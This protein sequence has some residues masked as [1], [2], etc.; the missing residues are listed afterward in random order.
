MPTFTVLFVTLLVALG[1]W[2]G[3]AGAAP[4]EPAGPRP[5]VLTKQKPF[6]AV[7]AGPKQV[8]PGDT[9]RVR[10]TVYLLDD[11]HYL[12]KDAC[13]VEVTDPGPF[14]FGPLRYWPKPVKTLDP[15]EKTE[16]EVYHE[17]LT[18]Y[19]EGTVPPDAAAGRY[20][21]S[22]V[23]KYRGCNKTVCFFPARETLQVTID[24]V[25]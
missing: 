22:A 24:V 20:T 14:T 18:M 13:A 1:G 10:Y 7:A 9:F 25:R 12:Y 3:T 5:A 19:L 16:K 23:V 17:P 21:I 6:K 2:P 8:K 15:F 4:V 11:S